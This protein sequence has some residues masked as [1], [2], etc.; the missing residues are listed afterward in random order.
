[1]SETETF[2]INIY[3]LDDGE[4]DGEWGEPFAVY[5]PLTRTL[6]AGI[7]VDRADATQRYGRGEVTQ[8]GRDLLVWRIPGSGDGERDTALLHMIASHIAAGTE[9]EVPE[10]I[11][12]FAVI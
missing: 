6:R 1:M 7:A 5:N 10:A 9:D 4:L 3:T 8:H 11:R 2:G 12:E